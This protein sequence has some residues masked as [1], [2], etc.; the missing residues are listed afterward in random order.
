MIERLLPDAVATA[1]TAHDTAEAVL[2]PEEEDRLRGA[3]DARRLEFTTGRRCGRLAL[4]RL[5]VPDIAIPSGAH[6]EPLWPDGIVGSI[7][8]C[9]GY[10]AA[11]AARRGRIQGIGIDAEEHRPLPPELVETVLLPEERAHVRRLGAGVHWETLI[12]S[13]KESL[14]KAWFPLTGRWL[15]FHDARIGPE[16]DGKFTVD[17]RVPCHETGKALSPVFQGRW[18]TDGRI[19]VTSVIAGQSTS[20]PMN[21]YALA[22]TPYALPESGACDPQ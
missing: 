5:G 8:H 7:T 4:A 18:H 17:V 15:G 16:H 2:F 19:M 11:A 21:G 10:R 9:R 13:A 6:G 1:W 22:D 14:Y 12:F 20:V 3:V